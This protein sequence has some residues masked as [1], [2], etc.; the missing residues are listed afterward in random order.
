MSPSRSLCAF[1]AIVLA[2]AVQHSSGAEPPGAVRDTLEQRLR[3]CTV[4]H[5]KQ[6]EGLTKAEFYP[7]LAGKPAGYLFNQL[8]AF[9]DGKRRSPIMNYLVAYLAD[10]YLREIS[11]YYEGLKPP[12]P[13]PTPAAPQVAFRGQALATKGDPARN[14]PPCKACHGKSLTG[15]QPSIPGLVGLSSH[16]IA[17]QMGAWRIGQRQSYE[18]DCMREIASALTGEDIAAISGWLGS[19]PAPANAA[20]LPQG[21]LRLPMKCGGTPV[22]R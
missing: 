15:M 8:I 17:S 10:E 9:R 6:G 3:A 22:S 19:L 13:P 18:P 12:Y 20:P 2:F 16:Y 14:I 21:A 1:A 4:C 7:R 5:G 11:E